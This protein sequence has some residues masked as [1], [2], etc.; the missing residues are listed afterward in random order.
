[1]RMALFE[2]DLADGSPEQ[3][4]RISENSSKNNQGQDAIPAWGPFS[5]TLSFGFISASGDHFSDDQAKQKE[6][7]GWGNAGKKVEQACR[8][9]NFLCF[10]NNVCFF[11]SRIETFSTL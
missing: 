11:Y 8:P 4:S 5:L 1:M 2:Q 10:Q 3:G 7:C 9:Q 6:I